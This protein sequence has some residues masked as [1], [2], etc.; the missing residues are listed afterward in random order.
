MKRSKLRLA[1]ALALVLTL[2]LALA[3]TA[4][5]EGED[6]TPWENAYVYDEN[7][8]YNI[9]DT[10]YTAGADAALDQVIFGA[11][12][13]WVNEQLQKEEVT[14]LYIKIEADLYTSRQDT[15]RDPITIPDGKSL[16]LQLSSCKVGND[17]SVTCVDEPYFLV[18]PGGKLEITGN[19]WIINTEETKDGA[20]IQDHALILN[21][22]T[23]EISGTI[24]LE[25]KYKHTGEYSRQ[26]TIINYGT[27]EIKGADGNGIPN[28]YGVTI[29]VLSTAAGKYK[30][31]VYVGETTVKNANVDMATV[32]VES[33]TN[34]TDTVPSVEM[35]NVNIKYAFGFA[36]AENPPQV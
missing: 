16:H 27:L 18:E 11:F 32:F 22:G 23:T 24:Y 6:G 13:S 33:D 2:L 29:Y 12:A 10:N 36:D 15:K 8:K 5:A 30:G 21:Y 28:E 4:W 25:R 20:S 31:Q 14:H 3:P 17:H 34:P 1:V 35:T 19:G 9:V 7:N 26:H